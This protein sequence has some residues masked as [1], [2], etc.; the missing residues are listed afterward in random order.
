MNDNFTDRLLNASLQ[1]YSNV[2]P[3]EDFASRVLAKKAVA[4][5]TWLGWLWIPAAAAL[6]CGLLT[7]RPVPAAPPQLRARVGQ[8]SLPAA[9]PGPKKSGRRGC[10]PHCAPP[11]RVLT[12]IEL[13]GMALRP[14]LFA[15]EYAK[16][17]AEL[18]I[19]ELTVVP[20]EIATIPETEGE[21]QP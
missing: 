4:P 7:M 19:P 5:R 20:L 17:L 13:A 21:K 15:P 1:E 8:A 11:F 16:P 6:A 18:A 2:A 3:P 9:F 14:Q 10:L 12:G